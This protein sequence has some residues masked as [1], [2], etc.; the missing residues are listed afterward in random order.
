MW[1]SSKKLPSRPK[2][3]NKSRLPAATGTMALQ[4]SIKKSPTTRLRRTV[5]PRVTSQGFRNREDSSNI[6]IWSTQTRARTAFKTLLLTASRLWR[7]RRTT[8]AQFRVCLETV[9]RTTCKAT[10]GSSAS[11]AGLKM[12]VKPTA[13]VWSQIMWLG[14]VCECSHFNESGRSSSYA[15]IPK[16]CRRN[17][18]HTNVFRCWSRLN[19]LTLFTKDWNKCGASSTCLRSISKWFSWI[20]SCW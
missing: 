5:M 4:R 18:M 9:V 1:A 2:P 7:D 11:L 12:W 13:T 15:R 17:S 16:V 8:R 20:T 3:A 14:T 10:R 6:W 19:R